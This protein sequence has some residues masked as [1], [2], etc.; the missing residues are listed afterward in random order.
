MEGNIH[1]ELFADTVHEVAGHP[2]VVT[3]VN[4]LA[5]TNLVLPLAWHDLSVGSTDLNTGG[6]ERR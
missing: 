2:H 6:L 3:R 5:W 1:A 4:A